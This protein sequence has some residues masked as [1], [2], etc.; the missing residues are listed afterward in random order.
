MNP[1]KIVIFCSPSGAGK[2]T[3]T[4][5]MMKQFPELSFSISAT[6]REARGGEQNGVEYYFVT[7][8]AFKKMIEEGKFVEWEEVYPGRYYGTLK[9]EVERIQS[10]GKVPIFDIDVKGA[11]NLKQMY[12]D[13][14]LMFFIKAP[15]EMIKIGRASCRERV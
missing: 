7:T 9:S 15:T 2:T 13:N 1:N 3:I 6:S 11:W 5:A 12:G 14:A 10:I 4:R 8:D